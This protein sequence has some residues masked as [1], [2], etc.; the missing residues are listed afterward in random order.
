MKKRKE[1]RDLLKNIRKGIRLKTKAPRVE[2]PASVY[3][4]KDK[5]KRR[6][7]DDSSFFIPCLILKRV[8][9][10]SVRGKTSQQLLPAGWMGQVMSL[11]H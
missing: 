6:I 11:E 10:Q 9:T 8:I 1:Q 5:H 7:A 3:S 2:T 4:R